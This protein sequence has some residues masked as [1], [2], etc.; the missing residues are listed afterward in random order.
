MSSPKKDW[1]N[2][3]DCKT[4]GWWSKLLSRWP[5]Q[6]IVQVYLVYS[7]IRPIA[8]VALTMLF[9]L[10]L[11]WPGTDCDCCPARAQAHVL[12]GKA[13]QVQ[14]RPHAAWLTLIQV[15][16]IFLAWDM[17][18]PNMID[19]HSDRWHY[20]CVCVLLRVCQIMKSKNERS[21]RMKCIFHPAAAAV[22][23]L[24]ITK[25]VTVE[26]IL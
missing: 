23:K 15:E 17:A 19:V 1:W 14:A 22:S 9:V 11:R 12:V 4:S 3:C 5:L 2:V 13:N 26:R 25:S 18:H 24:Q 10:P 20:H 8:S 7:A 6:G 21:G 16:G